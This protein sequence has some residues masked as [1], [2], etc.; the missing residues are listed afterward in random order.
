MRKKNTHGGRREGAGRKP[1]NGKTALIGVRLTQ[2]LRTQL[3]AAAHA[4]GVTVSKFVEELI[5]KNWPR[6]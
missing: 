3:K 6:G 1:K 5:E 2:E 4:K